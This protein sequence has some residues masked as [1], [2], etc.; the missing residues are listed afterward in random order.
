MLRTA[1]SET[2]AKLAGLCIAV[3]YNQ[4]VVIIR[5]NKGKSM[6]IIDVVKLQSLIESVHVMQSQRNA[7]R[8]LNA[9]DRVLKGQGEG[10]DIEHLKVDAK[11]SE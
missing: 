8:L 4:D 9:L 2:R 10:S 6:A 3:I 11:L 1:C 5:L 7:E